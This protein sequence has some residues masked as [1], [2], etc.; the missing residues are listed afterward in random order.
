MPLTV[1]PL[2]VMSWLPVHCRFPTT[3]VCVIALPVPAFPVSWT[4]PPTLVGPHAPMCH[5]EAAL[6]PVIC[7]LPL[8]VLLQITLAPEL[9]R[10]PAAFVPVTWR[11]P[12]T[13]EPASLR[14]LPLVTCTLPVTVTSTRSHHFPA[15][16]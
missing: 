8:I 16:T 10:S 9:I 12:V 14:P 3:V 13:V 2:P 4:L 7:T 5:G 1:L 6:L 15:G 11:L